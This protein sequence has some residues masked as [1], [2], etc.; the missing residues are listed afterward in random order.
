MTATPKCCGAPTTSAASFS[1][2]TLRGVHSGAE[3]V[4][5][6][7]VAHAHNAPAAVGL[8]TGSRRRS[9]ALSSV[10]AGPPQQALR[11]PG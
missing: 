3:Q 5:P 7:L 9:C 8:V 6:A 1:S 4:I 2:N 11:R 10:A